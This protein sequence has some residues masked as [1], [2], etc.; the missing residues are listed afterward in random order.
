MGVSKFFHGDGL[1]AGSTR[2]ASSTKASD[3]RPKVDAQTRGT[4]SLIISDK[5]TGEESTAYDIRIT[6]TTPSSTTA[7]VSDMVFQGVQDRSPHTLE[8][9]LVETAPIGTYSLECISPGIED[10]QA[11]TDYIIES[12]EFRFIANENL[13]AVNG[14]EGNYLR[15]SVYA[16]PPDYSSLALSSAATYPRPAQNVFIEPLF[17]ADFSVFQEDRFLTTSDQ[18]SVFPSTWAYPYYPSGSQDAGTIVPYI[19]GDDNYSFTNVST[20]DPVTGVFLPHLYTPRFVIG[21]PLSDDI[22]ATTDEMLK[23]VFIDRVFTEY[24]QDAGDGSGELLYY[25]KAHARS[26]SSQSGSQGDII[27]GMRPYPIRGG[28]MVHVYKLNT[29]DPST[30]HDMDFYYTHFPVESETGEITWSPITTWGELAYALDRHDRRGLYYTESESPILSGALRYPPIVLDSDAVVYP[31]NRRFSA[32]ENREI[33]FRTS[34]TVYPP[35]FPTSELLRIDDFEIVDRQVIRDE[36][37]TVQVTEVLEGSAIFDVKAPISATSASAPQGLPS[38]VIAKMREGDR[39][40]QVIAASAPSF[41]S[42]FGLDFTIPLRVTQDDTSVVIVSGEANINHAFS[43]VDDTA[44]SPR[45]I[46]LCLG[47]AEIT[48]NVTK[49]LVVRG[50]WTQF[51]EEDCEPCDGWNPDPFDPSCLGLPGSADGTNSDTPIEN[52]FYKDSEGNSIT[53]MLYWGDLGGTKNFRLPFVLEKKKWEDQ[54]ELDTVLT[55]IDTAT[56]NFEALALQYSIIDRS[57]V[58]S[59]NRNHFGSPD[60]SILLGGDQVIGGSFPTTAIDPFCDTLTSGCTEITTEAEDNNSYSSWGTRVDF[61]LLR[62]SEFSNKLIQGIYQA[63]FDFLRDHDKE[64]G[65]FKID[66]SAFVYRREGRVNAAYYKAFSHFDKTDYVNPYWGASAPSIASNSS[67]GQDYNQSWGALGADYTIPM[68]SGRNRFFDRFLYSFKYNFVDKLPSL[69]GIST[70]SLVDVKSELDLL[71]SSW[72]AYNHDPG[73]FMEDNYSTHSDWAD[74]IKWLYRLPQVK[75][76]YVDQASQQ[77]FR[78]LTELTPFSFALGASISKSW[79]VSVT[80]TRSTTAYSTYWDP[81]I[82]S[83]G[84]RYINDYPATSQTLTEVIIF[85]GSYSESE[86]VT[87]L[88]NMFSYS[89]SQPEQRNDDHWSGNTLVTEAYTVNSTIHSF[90]IS[91]AEDLDSGV[92]D[93]LKDRIGALIGTELGVG[94][95]NPSQWEVIHMGGLKVA[96]RPGDKGAKNFVLYERGYPGADGVNSAGRNAEEQG[97]AGERAMDQ[98]FWLKLMKLIVKC[99]FNYDV[100]NNLLTCPRENNFTNLIGCAEGKCTFEVRAEDYWDIKV[101]D[102]AKAGTEEYPP[103]YNNQWY[104]DLLEQRFAFQIVTRCPEKLQYGDSFTITFTPPGQV[105]GENGTYTIGQRFIIPCR[106]D[107]KVRLAEGVSDQDTA[108]WRFTPP[109]TST[110]PIFDLRVLN[111]ADTLVDIP[112]QDLLGLFSGALQVVQRFSEGDKFIFSL[113]GGEFI[114][115]RSDGTTFGPT[116]LT[117]QTQEFFSGDGVKIGFAFNSDTPFVLGD[118]WRVDLRQNNASS[119]AQSWALSQAW[120]TGSNTNE[121]LEYGLGVGNGVGINAAAIITNL[122]PSGTAILEAKD[123]GDSWGSPPFQQTL[124]R[125]DNLYFGFSDPPYLYFSLAPTTAYE[126]WRIR[127]TDPTL[128]SIEVKLFKLFNTTTGVVTLS[129]DHDIFL[130]IDLT[131]NPFDQQNTKSYSGLGAK[132]N[133]KYDLISEESFEDLFQV[134]IESRQAGNRPF[135]WLPNYNNLR[136]AFVCTFYSNNLSVVRRD[137]FL[138]ASGQNYYSDVNLPLKVEDV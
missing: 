20:V 98:V 68:H 18:R 107:R 108:K 85:P 137:A 77:R 67:F 10:Q 116:A 2:S 89:N 102:S 3:I 5:Y 92:S 131:V 39:L 40:S 103:A 111:R 51:S 115:I 88:N 36:E 106:A 78:E 32:W 24:T 125:Y 121:T 49:T 1:D 46:K 126:Q 4:A 15:I 33:A 57:S 66:D 90:N 56:A 117:P 104:Y 19:N 41:L 96:Q 87:R 64:V 27:K 101:T 16:T 50:V 94:T 73:Q 21:Y 52:L 53:P 134:F 95:L 100:E 132:I 58:G 7:N 45:T 14:T 62:P 105:E 48:D 43:L 84:Q 29:A 114:V 23:K 133:S 93:N 54:T 47:G 30:T 76:D 9:S 130:P 28:Y 42:Q 59:E 124:T 82:P 123:N 31:R 71:I 129:Q 70:E 110:L 138:K 136:A 34:G 38:Q 127:L 63:L 69:T 26:N 97:F 91:G 8:M 109:P 22:P 65:P 37:I 74:V 13:S 79:R 122:T 75:Q 17:S 118:Q 113:T 135:I 119:H 25:L 60:Y 11:V 55:A 120:S 99:G 80:Y 83:D 12:E 72:V 6:S 61:G 81:T 112:S 128:D 35:K 44:E 86:V